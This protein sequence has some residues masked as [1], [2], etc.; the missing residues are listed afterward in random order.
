[1]KDIIRFSFIPFIM[2]YNSKYCLLTVFIIGIFINDGFAQSQKLRDAF[3]KDKKYILLDMLDSLYEVKRYTLNTQELY[4]VDEIIEVYNIKIGGQLL[5]LSVM[6]DFLSE[7][8]WTE[9]DPEE[10][11]SHILN[12]WESLRIEQSPLF[13]RSDLYGTENKTMA[14]QLIKQEAGKHFISNICL[15][16]MFIPTNYPA[17]VHPAIFNV[18]QG[19]IN[20]FQAP[21]SII[22]MLQVYGKSPGLLEG[23]PFPLDFRKGGATILPNRAQLE[24]EYLSRTIDING[25]IAY[26]FWTLTDWSSPSGY[27]YNRGVDRFIY[28]PDKGIVGGSY[29]FYFLVEFDTG[30]D[31]IFKPKRDLRPRYRKTKEE[32]WQNVIQEKVIL[33][34]ELKK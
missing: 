20:T 14:F 1:M 21:I 12:E 19:L 11:D 5:L 15:T 24:R 30:W 9:V 33:A 6:P 26:Q 34:E 25:E 16:E 3:T 18:K 13:N 32:L 27:N 29:D 22:Q 28:I 31:H 8:N 4:G 7:S 17:D 10:I 2:F 23:W